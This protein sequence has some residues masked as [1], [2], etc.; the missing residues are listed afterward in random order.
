MYERDWTTSLDDL[1]EGRADNGLF[2]IL[3]S[4]DPKLHPRHQRLVVD[5]QG[6]EVV[7]QQVV[8][9]D[10]VGVGSD[11][12]VQQRRNG[13]SRFLQVRCAY[14]QYSEARD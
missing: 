7:V 14:N 10:A 13:R 2:L 3:P 5:V 1:A 12:E 9:W 8:V 6:A 11:A 4:P